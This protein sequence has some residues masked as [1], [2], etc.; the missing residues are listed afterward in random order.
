MDQKRFRCVVSTVVALTRLSAVAA[1][2][3]SIFE[4]R[5]RDGIVNVERDDPLHGG[6]I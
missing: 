2:A 3:E 6:R 4:N 1:K 5:R